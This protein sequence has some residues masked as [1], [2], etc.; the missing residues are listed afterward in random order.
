MLAGPGLIFSGDADGAFTAN[1]AFVL[2]DP[3]ADAAFGID[4]RLLEPNL[5]RHRI[6]GPERMFKWKFSIHR[7]TAGCVGDDLPATQTRA[8]RNKTKI[9]SAGKLICSQGIGLELDSGGI[10]MLD[11]QRMRHVDVF[12]EFPCKDRFRADRAIFLADDT[13]SVHGPWQAAAAVDK[14]GADFYGALFHM[15]AE[16]LAFLEADGPDRRCRAEVAAG[17][18]VVLTPAGADSKIEHRCPQAL[19]TGCQP[20]RVND[21]GRADAHALAAFYAAR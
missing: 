8:P 4:I 5:N 14:G 11:N 1:R 15:L 18:T 12:K 6:L 7:Q 2:A 3:A 21:I 19:Q 16:P 10:G 20:G 17:D 13:G 9:I